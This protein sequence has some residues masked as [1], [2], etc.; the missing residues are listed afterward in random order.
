MKNLIIKLSFIIVTIG[1]SAQEN[2]NE[3]LAAG[4]QDAEHFTT[5]YISPASEGV[6][7]A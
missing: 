6:A 7:F 4:I 1:V 5:D 2:I 3:M